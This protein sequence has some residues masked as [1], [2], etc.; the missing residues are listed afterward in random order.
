MKRPLLQSFACAFRGIY[1]A[2]AT[3]RNF[4]IHLV[5]AVIA[6]A[7]GI[8]L[9][10]SAIAWCLIVFAISVVLMAEC[11]NTAL[12]RMCD[13]ISGGEKSD[14]IRNAKDIAAGA[15]WL[16]AIAALVIGIVLLVV[17]L[18]HRLFD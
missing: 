12:E 4:K 8:Y 14:V 13:H 18:V 5:A 7:L 10:L 2:M 16:A 1:I 15:V 9:G 17:P 6:I 3:E 11:M